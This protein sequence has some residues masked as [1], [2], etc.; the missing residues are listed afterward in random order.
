[1][2]TDTVMVL[3]LVFLELPAAFVLGYGLGTALEAARKR[4]EREQK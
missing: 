4:K 1:M 2:E 3:A